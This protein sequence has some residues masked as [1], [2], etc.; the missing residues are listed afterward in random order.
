MNTTQIRRRLSRYILTKRRDDEISQRAAASQIGMSASM[1][2]DIECETRDTT[3]P[4]YYAIC[5][6]LGVDPG[7]M[8]R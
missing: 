5:A 3:V 8:L 1:L 6:W 4:K 7:E 2:N